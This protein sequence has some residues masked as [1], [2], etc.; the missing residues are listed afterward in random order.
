MV[1]PRTQRFLAERMNA[2]I[3]SLAVDHMPLLSA[4]AAVANFIAEAVNA[5]QG[6]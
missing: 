5:V 2:R 1:A 6:A 4:P 3:T